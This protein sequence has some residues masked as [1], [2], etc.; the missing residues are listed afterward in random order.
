MY[1]KNC[2]N[3]DSIAIEM[4][5]AANFLH[6]DDLKAKAFKV[7]KRTL[8]VDNAMDLYR[9]VYLHSG[10]LSRF[11]R[12]ISRNIGVVQETRAYQE[13][14]KSDPELVLELLERA[15]Y[16]RDNPRWCPLDECGGGVCYYSQNGDWHPGFEEYS[17]EDSSDS[18]SEY[19]DDDDREYYREYGGP[20]SGEFPPR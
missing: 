4:Y 18:A 12:F 10:N 6:L 8:S 9:I 1:T 16:D 13:A 14:R 15:V 11:Y 3:L 20:D 7:L 17:D 2:N 19:Y 5:A